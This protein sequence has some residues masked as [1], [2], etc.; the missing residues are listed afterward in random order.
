MSTQS[1]P[2]PSYPP[3]RWFMLAAVTFGYVTC[4][5]L[6]I[7]FAPVLGEVASGYGIDVGQ[8]TV[9]AMASY[10][11]FSAVAVLIAGPLI[12]RFGVRPLIVIGGAL[13][14]ASCLLMPLLSGTLAG[15][16]AL[17]ALMGLGSGPISACVSAVAARWFPP[18][19][20]GIFAGAQGSG[21]ALGV[22]LGFI[23][24]PLAFDANGGDW[25]AAIAWLAIVP[26]ISLALCVVPLF[27]REPA[28]VEAVA[29]DPNAS[30]DFARALREPVFYIGLLGMFA[31]CWIMNAFNQ[32]TPAFFA[33]DAPLGLGLG[34]LAAGQKM[35][36]VQVGM[37]LGGVAT[38]IALDKVFKGNARPVLIAG[39][40]LAAVCM[41][42][43]RF[44]AVNRDPLLLGAF[45]FGAGFFESVAIPAISTFISLNYPHGIMGK[46]FAVSFGVSLFGGAI[47]VGIG[48]A[49]LSATNSYA[50]PMLLVSVVAVAGALVSS[51]LRPTRAFAAGTG[52]GARG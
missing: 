9:A 35:I 24:M 15:L 39:F 6:I 32:Q 7:M 43:V 11:L 47:G 14:V 42:A 44:P 34:A 38:G 12:D 51:L 20:R 46:V 33:V 30:G 4:G 1:T 25:R 31:F 36:A 45:L 16:V 22:A 18:H 29:A 17:R 52:A 21:M 26:A 41:L 5:M 28:V 49:I 13:L 40:L 19:E 23:A 37:I 2:S 10:I 3:F 8:A 27:V 50:V 48:G